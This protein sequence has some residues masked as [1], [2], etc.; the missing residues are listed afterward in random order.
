MRIFH[1]LPSIWYRISGRD[2]GSFLWVNHL[3]FSSSS[4]YRLLRWLKN[5]KID[6]SLEQV[7]SK[8]SVYISMRKKIRETVHITQNR[9]QIN[10][11]ECILYYINRIPI[12]SSIDFLWPRSTK[13]YDWA[14]DGKH[15]YLDIFI[16]M[17]R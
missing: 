2:R 10:I 14:L 4:Q 13:N 6:K 5:R 12:F 16:T 17:N 7:F 8:D 1:T 11:K 9:K 3:L 15:F